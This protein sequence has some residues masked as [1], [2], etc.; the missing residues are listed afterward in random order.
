MPQAARAAPREEPVD[1]PWPPLRHRVANRD[2]A[3]PDDQLDPADI[4]ELLRIALAELATFRR[5]YA[6]VAALE[7]VFLAIE[8]LTGLA[9][10]HEDRA[11]RHARAI[12]FAR[13]LVDREGLDR[14]A[15]A[16][17][18]SAALGVER[19]EILEGL[20]REAI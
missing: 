5:R 16:E 8:R 11:T 10:E 4:A 2:G 6:R 18:A 12:R 1:E 3:A 20:R 7:P 13:T 19:F 9:L 15:A 14:Q 17:R